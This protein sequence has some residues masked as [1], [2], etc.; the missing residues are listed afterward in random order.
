MMPLV[1]I[2]ASGKG[3]L[4][5]KIDIA[6]AF[7]I[8]SVHPSDRH[9]LGMLWKGGVFI[10]KQLPFGLRSAPLIF[11]AYA[12][13]L[14]WI[15]QDLGVAKIIHYLDDFLVVG[16]P[17]SLG[18]SQ[19]LECMLY[20][21]NCLVVPLADDKIV[22]PSSCLS[23]LGNLLDTT[24]RLPVDK[25]A[26]LKQELAVWQEKKSCTRKELEHLIGVLQ[27]ACRVVAQGRTFVCRMIN[28]LCIASKP[29][30]HIRLN[31]E[32]QSILLWWKTFVDSWN[33]IS[34]LQLTHQL[35]PSVNVFSDASGGFGYGA[36]WDVRWLHGQWPQDWF[37]VNIMVKEL[38]PFVVA[39][40]IWGSQWS[41]QFVHFHIDNMSVVDILKK[42]SSSGL[43]MHLLRCLFFFSAFFHFF[44][45]CVIQ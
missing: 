45:V 17:D 3:A 15:L 9:L 1:L 43:V 39:A 8:I 35:I 30:H 12:D 31:K 14:E 19:F 5:A 16:T 33:G 37:A 41:G 32:F 10:N 20:T 38:V 21:C 34:F 18:S 24:T 29:Y 25:L 11:N 13:A 28:L 44:L 6:S 36:I 2:L 4:L 23:F 22:S 7:R 42:G 27:F 26:H 40:A